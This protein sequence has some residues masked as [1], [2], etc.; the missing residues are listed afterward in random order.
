MVLDSVSLYVHIPF[1]RQKCDYCDFYS[2][3]ECNR[4]GKV[5]DLSDDYINSVINEIRCYVNAYSIRRWSTV[6]IGGGTPSLLSEKQLKT[7]CKGIFSAVPEKSDDFEFT[8]EMNPEN[9]SSQYLETAWACGVNRISLGVQSLQD[10]VLARVNRGCDS[11]T[12]LNALEIVSKCWKGRFSVDFIAGLP[13]ETYETF[14]QNLLKAMEYSPD[15]ISLYTLTVEENTPLW[16]KIQ[17]G[18]I[19][20]SSEKADKMWLKGR[21]ILEL[22]GFVHYEVSNFAKPGYKSRHNQTYWKQK[23][24]IGAG[25]GATGTIYELKTRWTNTM[26]IPDYIRHFNNIGTNY[27]GVNSF[28]RSVELLDEQ[29]MKFEFL[30]MGFRMREGIV[31]QDYFDR[32]NENLPDGF[33]EVFNRWQKKRLAGKEKTSRGTRYYLNRR[34]SLFLNL[35]LE[36]L[37]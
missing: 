31:D 10:K 25:C 6:Y 24:Y 16:Q 1:C 8:L 29:T 14:R 37:I 5:N 11:Q 4:R 17:S 2:V 35:F 27:G 32:F 26:S 19:K 3:A 30:M 22:N 23:N 34:G 21:N 15:H 33:Y 9:V 20:W 36:E 12:A 18:K 28:P 7:L 13:G